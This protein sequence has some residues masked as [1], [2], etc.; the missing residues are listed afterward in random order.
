MFSSVRSL[1]STSMIILGAALPSLAQNK[2]VVG[3]WHN[4]NNASAP[5]IRLGDVPNYYN[6]ID[7]AFAVPVSAT[8]MTMQF[9]PEANL[10]S[11]ASFIADMRTLQKR[12]TK[13]LLSLGGAD[14]TVDIS[15]NSEKQ[16]FIRTLDSL[17][18]KYGFN[19]LDIDVEHGMQLTGGD[20]DFKNPTT[21]NIVNLIDALKT[22]RAQNGGADFWITSAPEVAYVQGGFS[23]YGGIWGAYLPLLWG[24]RNELNFVHV[25]YYNT[26]ST[27]TP[28]GHNYNQGTADFIVAMTDMLLSGFT[29]GGSPANNFPGFRE[30][31]VVFG[32][33]A[34]PGAAGGGYMSF[35]EVTK[36]LDYLTKGIPFGGQYVIRKTG[37]YPAL[38][39][40]MTWSVNWD[41]PS[42]Y[43]FGKTYS[44]YF[45][46][47][48]PSRI[49]QRK[50]FAHVGTLP[51]LKI[52]GVN[53]RLL[54]LSNYGR[55]SA[56]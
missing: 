33:P 6:V 43:S 18:K 5:F 3:Y 27:G 14:G 2:V 20:G 22:L 49:H 25:Q 50:T 13:I 16:K 15:T 46:I 48:T 40:I 11:E 7:I 52:Y 36:A 42:Q 35:T 24:I 44:A 28:D 21:P 45:K 37:G 9:D 39:G 32:L 30:D 8:D 4:W 19:G 17:I 1:C 54:E 38:R 31:Q 56:R 47:G 23:A 29:V 34:A 41:A 51:I 10:Q 26:G 55:I 53:G 12:G